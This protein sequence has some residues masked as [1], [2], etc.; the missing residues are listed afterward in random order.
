MQTASVRW[1]AILF[2]TLF[3]VTVLSSMALPADDADSAAWDAPARAAQKKNPVAADKKSV[4]VGKA[5]YIAQCVE[6]HGEA[7]KG[8]GPTAK[9]LSP[10]PKDLSDSKMASQT[11]GTLFW[12]IST[13][14]KPMPAIDDATSENDR[15][16]AVNYI[17]TLA[18]VPASQ[19]AK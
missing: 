8:D 17:R 13:G 7:G 11:D 6:C 5:V 14:R 18:P 16:S 15:W 1:V 3:L 19:P 10:R 4:A 2:I 9:D 12:K